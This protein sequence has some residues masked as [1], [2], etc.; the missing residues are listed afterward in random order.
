MRR[1]NKIKKK[2]CLHLSCK[3]KKKNV[4]FAMPVSGYAQLR[5]LNSGLQAIYLIFSLINASVV[6]VASMYVPPEP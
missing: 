6:G 5:Q 3:K 4:R 1:T 2:R